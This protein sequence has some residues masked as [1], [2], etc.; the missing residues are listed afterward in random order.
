M[1]PGSSRVGCA[2]SRIVPPLSVIVFCSSSRQITGCGVFLSN[3]VECAPSRLHT[4]RPNSITAHCMPRQRPEKRNAFGAGV[5]DR[6]HFALDAALAEAARHEDA[7]V[8]REQSLRPFGFDLLALNAADAHLCAVGD[9]RVV[10][11]FVDRLVGVVVLGVF[12][13]DRDADLVLRIAQPSQQLA[14]ILQI[15]LRQSSGPSLS[16]ISRSRLLSTR[17][18]GTS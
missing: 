3:S 16:T 8:A 7:V 15:G 10:E 1:L 18:S 12:A 9:A 14:P 2:P 17:L 13:D 5:A 11:R 4:L 6:H